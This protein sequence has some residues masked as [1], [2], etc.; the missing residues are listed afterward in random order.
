MAVCYVC[1][2]D[3]GM[4][5]IGIHEPQ[6][7]KK[8]HM[9]NDKLPREMRRKPPSKPDLLP[10]ISGS[11]SVDR[12]R[13]NQ[14][15]WQSAQAQLIACDNCGRSFLPD[16]LPVHQKSCRSINGKTKSV[17]KNQ[18]SKTPINQSEENSRPSTATLEGPTVLDKRNMIDVSKS[19]HASSPRQP[20]KRD[21]HQSRPKSRPS[22]VTISRPP[23][24]KN[25]KP[26]TPY[27]DPPKRK[28]A[29]RPNFV[30]CYICGRQ[31]TP[32]S[33][34]IHEPQCLEKWKVENQRLPREMRRPLPK[35][36]EVIPISGSGSYN[37][38]QMNEAAYVAAQANL[39]PCRMCGRTFAQDRIQKHENVCQKVGTKP[40]PSKPNE[41]FQNRENHTPNYSDSK[42]NGHTTPTSSAMSNRE[43]N[44]TNSKELSNTSKRS[45][46]GPRFVICYIC[47]RQF[48]TASLPIHEPKCLEKWQIENQKLPK[49]QRRP[50]PRKPQS[51]PTDP[52]SPGFNAAR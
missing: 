17:N 40:P 28:T 21:P 51:L 35:K 37:V 12:E 23:L 38:D 46:T 15:A 22:T 44:S 19:P 41:N 8:W 32:A 48:T 20:T 29:R 16:R 39:V 1:G 26:K 3:F 30:F 47:G 27:G 18:H 2:R 33:L 50:L 5:S 6:C 49:E 42:M 31:F 52:K 43:N 25:P 10:S 24:E 45:Q 11:N 4:K 14:A 13:M 36:P 9:E 34:P 7:M